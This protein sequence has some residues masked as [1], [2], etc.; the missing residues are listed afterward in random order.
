[1]ASYGTYLTVEGG[2]IWHLVAGCGPA[3]PVLAIHGIPG[4]SSRYLSPLL[5]V[6]EDRPVIF[7]DQLGGGASDRPD[8]LSLWTLPR[9]SH[10]IE[11]IRKA[12]SLSE[13]HLFGHSWGAI[14]AVEHALK[15][16]GVRSLVLTSAPLDIPAYVEDIGR[17]RMQLLAESG[18]GRVGGSEQPDQEQVSAFQAR[19]FCR[20]VPWPDDVRQSV[21][22]LNGSVF[23][24]LWGTDPFDCTGSLSQYSAVD[25]LGSIGV[26]TLVAVG[27]HDATTPARAATYA[28]SVPRGELVILEDS[29]H[30]A[31]W[32]QRSLY[33]D[34]IR[35]F[36][37]RVD[38]SA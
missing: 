35:A 10:E 27:A 20:V 30:M 4:S 23:A 38:A 29:S 7:Y 33:C 26:P 14:L 37:R 11:A 5:A 8:D 13:V 25:R 6:A 12:L 28:A 34:T 3:I 19:H 31:L 9:F 21:A 17:L 1:M 18:E 36:M 2:N 15:H 24:E 22:T 16:P 32:E